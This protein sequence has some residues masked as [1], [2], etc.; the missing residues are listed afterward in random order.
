MTVINQRNP[1]LTYVIQT[2]R[3]LRFP[4]VYIENRSDLAAVARVILVVV[5]PL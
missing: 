4:R 3:P 5:P 2:A 1:A